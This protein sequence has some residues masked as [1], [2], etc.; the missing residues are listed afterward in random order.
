M[1]GTEARRHGGTKGLW[2]ACALM[3]LGL[4]AC[5]FNKSRIYAEMT[6]TEME[7]I[8][9]VYVHQ[10]MPK[11]EVEDALHTIRLPWVAR[12]TEQI[13]ANVLPRHFFY[14][15]PE[16]RQ[17]HPYGQLEF[18]FAENLLVDVELIKYTPND[19][20]G[21]WTKFDLTPKTGRT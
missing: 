4:G 8:L 1:R 21:S 19:Q 20:D 16:W 12:S 10:D 17:K 14:A 3:C 13:V 18:N 5:G 9:S 11:G 6:P 15:G 2:F 7:T